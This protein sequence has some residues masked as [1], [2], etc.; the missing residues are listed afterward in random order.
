MDFRSL[1]NLTD[2]RRV[3][4]QELERVAKSARI[5]FV[6]NEGELAVD[7]GEFLSGDRYKL[8]IHL[9]F[10]LIHLPFDIDPETVLFR[11]N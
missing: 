6:I 4:I 3:N 10:F 11:T 2:M 5:A 8:W 7:F 9:I 1:L